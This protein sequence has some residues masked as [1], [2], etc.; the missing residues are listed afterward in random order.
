[1]AIPPA[2]RLDGRI[3]V[4]GGSFL[5]RVPAGADVYL[6]IWV[7]HDWSDEDCLRI[8]RTC[9]AAMA[10][11]AKL[12]IVEQILEPDPACGHP[13]S[14]LIDT[15]MM[16][17]FGSALERTESEFR[18]LLAA[19]GFAFVRLMSTASTVSIIEASPA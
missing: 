18:D 3:T 14:Y 2:D 1:M 9:R 16:A 7:L 17:M 15:H 5:D 12:L 19:S 4:E 6:L 10:P 11:D 8:L 13:A